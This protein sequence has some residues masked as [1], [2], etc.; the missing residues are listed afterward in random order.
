MGHVSAALKTRSLLSYIGIVS[1]LCYSTFTYPLVAPRLHQVGTVHSISPSLNHI[2]S[3]PIRTPIPL[4]HVAIKNPPPPPPPVE[5]P[6]T[7]HPAVEPEP[8]V[9]IP[10]PPEPPVPELQGLLPPLLDETWEDKETTPLSNYLRRG[11]IGPNR[12]LF[13][14]MASRQYIEPMINFKHALDR[15]NEGQNY[16]VLCLDIEC[17]EAGIA[18]GI[19]AFDGYLQ[20]I[21]E[22]QGDWHYSVARMKV[23]QFLFDVDLS[24]LPISISSMADIILSYSMAMC[25]SP[26]HNTLSPVCVSSPITRGTSNSKPI[27]R[28]L[29]PQ[30]L[31]LAGTGLARLLLSANFFNG[32]NNGGRIP[33][34]RGIS[35]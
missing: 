16:I 6:T 27:N 15:W 34:A 21:T 14:T 23:F 12:T 35:Q 19:H 7:I 29:K 4:P 1:I 30:I 17:V 10:P 3:E 8:P 33:P 32:P 26:A 5:Y 31:T 28:M 2:I 11:G 18:H 9:E 13:I 22:A 24:L 20:T 25:I